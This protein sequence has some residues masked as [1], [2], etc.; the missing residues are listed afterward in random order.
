[1]ISNDSFT[2]KS[3]IWASFPSFCWKLINE[4][5]DPENDGLKLPKCHFMACMP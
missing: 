1:M 3:V 2:E 5:F 4:D